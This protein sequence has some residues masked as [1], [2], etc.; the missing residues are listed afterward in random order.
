MRKCF[1]NIPVII[2]KIRSNV[3]YDSSTQTVPLGVYS[4]YWLNTGRR[5]YIKIL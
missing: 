5:H 3:S 2:F 4:T 1:I